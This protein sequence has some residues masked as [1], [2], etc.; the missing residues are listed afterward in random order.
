MQLV[1]V[2]AVWSVRMRCVR[3]TLSEEGLEG[4]FDEAG[5]VLAGG[6]NLINPE[7]TSVVEACAVVYRPRGLSEVE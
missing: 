5:T 1:P 6:P 4:L 3:R 2:L 7:D